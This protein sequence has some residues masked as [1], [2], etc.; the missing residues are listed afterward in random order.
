M[1]EKVRELVAAHYTALV[2]YLNCYFKIS[3]RD[4]HFCRFGRC[5]PRPGP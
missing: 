4:L 3:Q 2:I 5:L 1:F